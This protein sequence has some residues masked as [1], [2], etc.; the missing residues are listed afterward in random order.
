M[1]HGTMR[2]SIAT[3]ELSLDESFALPGDEPGEL[4][5]GRLGGGGSAR[6][7]PRD[8]GHLP[9]EHPA[10]LDRPAR[11][12]RGRLGRQVRGRAASGRKPDL[13]VYLPGTPPPPL[14]G[15]VRAPPVIAIEIVSPTPRDGRR[16]RVLNVLPL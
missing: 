1:S 16:D 15:L 8:P 13:T 9:G 5:D 6:L 3:A 12:L 14:T 2:E 7:R 4:G 10:R 11:R